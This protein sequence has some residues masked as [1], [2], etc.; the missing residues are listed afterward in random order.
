MTS[1]ATGYEK[2]KLY[3][4]WIFAVLT[5]AGLPLFIWLIGDVMDSFGAAAS[6]EETEAQIK[7]LV[8][9]MGVLL[10]VVFVGG[11]LYQA[12]TLTSS[13]TIAAELRKRYLQAILRQDCA[14]FDQ[15]N[16]QEFN[17]RLTKEVQAIQKAIGEKFALIVFSV[18]LCLAGL[19]LGFTKGWTLASAMTLIGPMI[20]IGFLVFVA[21]MTKGVAATVRSY[22]VSAGYAE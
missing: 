21:N 17:A 22:S 16:Y 3:F 20:L 12:A 9:F 1:L 10:G 18:G 5:G 7:D 4:G 19:V 15:V 14:W 6:F 8:R 11:Y 2:C 13:I